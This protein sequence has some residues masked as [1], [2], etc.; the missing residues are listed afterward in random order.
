MEDKK[1]SKTLPIISFV[2]YITLIIT[3]Y[4]WYFSSLIPFILKLEGKSEA[5]ITQAFKIY[6]NFWMVFIA[7]FI[8]IYMVSLVLRILTIV[9]SG[10]LEKKTV[11]TLYI[12]GIFIPLCT[13]VGFILHIIEII[14]Y[15]KKIDLKNH[16]SSF[17]NFKE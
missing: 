8:L 12:L 7:I 15:N 13:T 11:L 17:N 3:T 5:Y 9:Q 16:Q 4:L 6:I 14:D 1:L 2:T 10:N